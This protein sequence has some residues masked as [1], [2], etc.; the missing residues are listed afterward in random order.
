MAAWMA[1][2]SCESGVALRDM[3][4]G[5]RE[6]GGRG[7]LFLVHEC[8]KEG[9]E[10]RDGLDHFVAAGLVELERAAVGVA[11]LLLGG[12]RQELAKQVEVG[13]DGGGPPPGGGPGRR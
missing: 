1:G 7:R 13:R 11:D 3:E 8:L 12:R 10:A 4:A 2:W 5:S 6:R 9:D